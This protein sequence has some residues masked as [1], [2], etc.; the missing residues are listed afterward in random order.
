MVHFVKM[1]VHLLLAND[2]PG[3]NYQWIGPNQFKSNEQNPILKQLKTEDSGTYSVSS[4]Y[5]GCLRLS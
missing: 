3:C 1:T 2:I 4:N 5:F